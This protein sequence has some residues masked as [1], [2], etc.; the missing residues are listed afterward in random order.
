MWMHK[1]TPAMDMHTEEKPCEN[2]GLS[3][4][5]QGEDRKSLEEAKPADTLIL[6]P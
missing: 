1:E 3:R 6:D 2:P 5:L 4:H